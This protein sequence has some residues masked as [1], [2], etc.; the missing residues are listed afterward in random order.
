MRKKVVL[1][2]SLCSIL[3]FTCVYSQDKADSKV[4]V[5]ADKE[6]VAYLQESSND[7]NRLK[8][9]LI[10]E[11]EKENTS[12]L[13]ENKELREELSRLKKQFNYIKENN[14]AK[15]YGHTIYFTLNKRYHSMFRENSWKDGTKFTVSGKIYSQGIGFDRADNEDR[16]YYFAKLYNEDMAYSKL[17]GYIGI[18][19][20]AKDLSDSEVTFTVFNNDDVIKCN[21]E[22][23]GDVLYKTKFKK[24]DGLQKID[25]NLKG[26]NNII[27][28][29]SVEQ[30]SNL[31]YFVL[32]EP[33]LK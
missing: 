2:L 30:S 15:F 8:D 12:L 31:N 27:V 21:N 10:T 33:K 7:T 6:N 17:T 4:S 3:I 20:L 24:S 11:I 13:K 25:I 26:A 9:E 22:F 5:Q 32:L 1:S 28:E 29:F 14:D 16:S 23:Y 19:D 18:D